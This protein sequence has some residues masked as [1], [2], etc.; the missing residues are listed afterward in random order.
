MSL[1]LNLKEECSEQLDS[2][3]QRVASLLPTYTFSPMRSPKISS[4]AL[5]I[6]GPTLALALKNSLQQKFIDV[7][8]C[9]SAVLCCRAAPIQKVSGV[10]CILWP[11]GFEMVA[12]LK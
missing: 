9:C 10:I 2:A 1:F 7:A 3:L 6:N 4:L 8:E 12:A 5:V 11:V